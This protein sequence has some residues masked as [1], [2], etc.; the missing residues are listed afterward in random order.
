MIFVYFFISG[1]IQN[2]VR[3]VARKST[4]K[5]SKPSN[6]SST[7]RA[8]D[9]FLISEHK[10]RFKTRPNDSYHHADFEPHQCTKE[11]VKSFSYADGDYKSESF[12]L[13]ESQVFNK[14]LSWFFFLSLDSNPLSIPMLCGWSRE[15]ARQQHGERLIIVY[16]GPCG[17][18]M[19]NM[20]EVHRYL[21][22]TG[23][24]LGVDLF[25][26]DSF[27]HCFTE[28]EPEVI[29]SQIKGRKRGKSLTPN[30]C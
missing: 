19:R 5:A 26:F 24:K 10:G 2:V 11:C 4:S 21:R 1:S 9:T 14:W 12:F 3:A 22:I 17:R 7:V 30:N 13:L 29:Y 16:R 18:R 20:G 8:E 6:L 25:C 23:S 27:V 15:I 28:Y